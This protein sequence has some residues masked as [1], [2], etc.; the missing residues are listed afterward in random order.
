MGAT[1]VVEVLVSAASNDAS[2][3]VQ[4]E[5]VEGLAELPDGAGV[6]ALIRIAREHPNREIRKKA[7]EAL[8]ESDDPRAKAAID[9]MLEQ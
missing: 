7:L 8:S 5:A 1:E 3:D 9:R 4:E 2:S 6:S